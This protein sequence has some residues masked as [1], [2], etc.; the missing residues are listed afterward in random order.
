LAA[1]TTQTAVSV[2]VVSR[3]GGPTLAESLRSIQASRAATSYSSE[4][5]VVN[6]GGGFE[7]REDVA[8]TAPD[9]QLI[10]LP[11]NIG[12]ASAAM[13]GIDAARGMWIATVNDDVRLEPVALDRLLETG[14]TDHRIGAVGAQL[15]F[16]DRPDIINSAGIDVDRLG[17]AFDR[18]LGEPTSASERQATEVFGVS[19]AAAIFRREMLERLGGFDTRFFGYLEDVDLAWRSQ[20]HGWRAVYEPTAVAYHHHSRT[21]R[22]SSDEK[23]FLVGRNRMRLLAKNATRRQLVVFGLPIAVYDLAY[24]SFVL[25]TQRSVAPLRGRLRGIGEWG[26]YRALA[27]DDRRTVTLAPIQGLRSAVHRNRQWTAPPT[28]A[29]NMQRARS[30]RWYAGRR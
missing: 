10:D 19:G 1:S 9:A 13:K 3:H 11:S 24:V 28:T 2:V 25:A 6:N 21:F 14:E 23:Y 5:L 29:A 17:V 12:Y 30:G 8:A 4:L 15:R 27:R 22:H 26:N 16:S 7:L 18:H 20:M